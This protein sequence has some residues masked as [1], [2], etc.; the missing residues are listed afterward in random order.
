MAE[1]PWEVGVCRDQYGLTPVETLDRAGILAHRV[2]GAHSLILTD[3]DVA[4]LAAAADYT[5]VACLGCYLKLAM[6]CT[7]VPRL[8]RAGVNVA[9]GTDSAATNNNLNLWEEI[10]LNATL[11]GFLAQ[12]PALVPGDA[13]L[14]MATLGGARALGASKELGTVEPGK[15]ADLIVLDLE[16]PHL[17]PREGALIGNLTHSA[18]GSEVR[19]V[20]IDGRVIMRDRS[21]VSFDEGE[22][23]RQAAAIV[24]RRRTAVGLPE[25]YRHRRP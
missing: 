3:G 13:A 9:L 11:H 1:S 14:R 6:G 22:V 4:R 7:P 16:R 5:A 24:R 19:D 21:I 25:A 8:M 2:I 18:N 15:K 12:D 20:I 17:Y 23:L 10:Q